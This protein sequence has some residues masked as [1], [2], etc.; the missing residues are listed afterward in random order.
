MSCDVLCSWLIF[1]PRRKHQDVEDLK[2]SGRASTNGALLQWCN[3]V[4]CFNM[5]MA[6]AS[7]CLVGIFW[8]CTCVL[9]CTSCT[10]L[11]T[12]SP[13]RAVWCCLYIGIKHW[14]P[15]FS[16]STLILAGLRRV[17]LEAENAKASM[18]CFCDVA[19]STLRWNQFGTQQTVSQLY[20]QNLEDTGLSGVRGRYG[21]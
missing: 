18:L 8:D 10:F 13:R 7:H 21:R 14:T 1:F 4:G 17:A 3:S 5:I 15:D 12:C 16:Y 20:S 19:V 11:H 6:C 2:R 9:V